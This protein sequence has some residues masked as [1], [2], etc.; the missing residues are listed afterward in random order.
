MG[1][2]YRS[3]FIQRLRHLRIMSD[4][5]DRMMSEICYSKATLP[6]CC[7]R[8]GE[9]LEAPYGEAFSDIYK[10]LKANTGEDFGQVYIS[11]MK[12]CLELLP[13]KDKDKEIFLQFAE[14]AGF[15]DGRMQL[16]SIE[17]CN[18][19]LK[20]EIGKLEKETAEKSRVALGLGAMSGL[21]L[22]IVLL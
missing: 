8:L 14:C 6:E 7:R 22:V 17:Q 21:L 5:F 19:M 4:I 2:W 15:E 18:D 3:Q 13:V 9:R 16:R 1:Y 20:T 12:L 11:R 10:Q